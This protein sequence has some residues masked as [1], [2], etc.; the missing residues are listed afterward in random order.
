MGNSS[1]SS[2][3]IVNNTTTNNETNYN[4]IQKST[5]N[6][7]V[8]SIMTAAANC[9]ASI[10]QNQ[11]T[12]L[13]NLVARGKGSKIGISQNQSANLNFS[14]VQISKMEN[15]I[16]T[17]MVNKIMQELENN[18][19]AEAKAQMKAA[20]EAKQAN[21]ALST[22]I[23]SS[24]SSNSNVT[25]NTTT[26]NVLNTNIQNIVTNNVSQNMKTSNLQECISN[27]VQNQNMNAGN[28]SALE[29]G[30]INLS[31]DQV[32]T[33]VAECKQMNQ[34]SAG[35]AAGVFA[36]LDIS[37][38]NDARTSSDTVA[39]AESKSTQENQGIITAL[40]G[41]I[42]GIIGSIGSIFGNIFGM[43]TG[44]IVLCILICL[45]CCLSLCAM[46]FMGGSGKS[47]TPSAEPAQDGGSIGKTLYNAGLF[48]TNYI[49]TMYMLSS[50]PS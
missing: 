25:N 31:Q 7:A 16:Q 47:S 3:N 22:A 48:D 27:L 36:D 38:K 42:S 19:S 29:G 39:S 6:V 15:K 33:S 32:A 10:D 18:F 13:G 50:T 23:A 21:G 49:S 12:T 45:C 44:A 35:I 8:E 46:M 20:A 2:S 14:C 37:A 24:S 11:N 43:A 34:M 26:N 1:S 9:S 28:L 40:G 5:T 17:D 4:N 41:A 30:E